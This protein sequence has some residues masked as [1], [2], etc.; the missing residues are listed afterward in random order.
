MNKICQNPTYLYSVN[1]IVIIMAKLPKNVAG[2]TSLIVEDFWNIGYG[3]INGKI[4]N[5][6]IQSK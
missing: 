4:A 5:Q 1:I 6:I 3:Y 2:A